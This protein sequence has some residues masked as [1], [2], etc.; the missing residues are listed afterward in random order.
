M[1][2]RID[3]AFLILVLTQALHSIEE[4]FGKLWE[5]LPPARFMSSLVSQ[6]LEIG[7]VIINI[8]LFIF[9]VWCLIFPIWRNYRFAPNV[10]WFW[11]IIELINGIGHP[12]WALYQRAYVPGLITAPILFIL[13]IY[14]SQQ[15]L[16]LDSIHKKKL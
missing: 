2:R 11:I 8:G 13:A 7:F 14:L 5:V 16:R 10:V 12:V 4:Y 15:L 3:I 6:N 1:N 9:G